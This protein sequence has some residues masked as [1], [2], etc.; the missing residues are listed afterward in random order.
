[1]TQ[2][3]YPKI[4]QYAT[5]GSN[6]TP[7]SERK[8]AKRKALVGLVAGAIQVTPCLSKAMTQAK[9]EPRSCLSKPKSK[10]S[11]LLLTCAFVYCLRVYVSV[12]GCVGVCWC[13]VV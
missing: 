8:G 6:T 9:H 13:F 11:G 5:T 4:W 1:M 3:N 12:Y 10:P 7:Q 2:D